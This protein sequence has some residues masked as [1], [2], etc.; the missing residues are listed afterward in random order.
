[1]NNLKEWNKISRKWAN[2]T[3][4]KRQ[5]I[6]NKKPKLIMINHKA[7]ETAL[8]GYKRII[9]IRIIIVL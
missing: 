8:M 7:A 1:M 3:F 9:H 5:M 6:N 4:E 2:K